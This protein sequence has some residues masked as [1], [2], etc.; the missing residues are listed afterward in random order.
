[1]A[2]NFQR[3]SN[4]DTK[5]KTSIPGVPK[6]YSCLINIRTKVFCLIFRI[7]SILDLKTKIVEIYRKLKKKYTILKLKI[8][9]FTRQIL[10]IFAKYGNDS[11]NICSVLSRQISNK[12]RDN[13]NF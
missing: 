3:K 13:Y 11:D 4:V 5:C 9:N 6:K 10:A 12:F 7:S 8:H 2:D 1:M